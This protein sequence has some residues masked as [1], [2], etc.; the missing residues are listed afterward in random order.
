MLLFFICE[1]RITLHAFFEGSNR[2]IYMRSQN[3][4]VYPIQGMDMKCEYEKSGRAGEGKKWFQFV[5][6]N[7]F[8]MHGRLV[9]HVARAHPVL[10]RLFFANRESELCMVYISSKTCLRTTRRHG[11][12]LLHSLQAVKKC[13]RIQLKSHCQS[14]GGA[15]PVFFL[16]VL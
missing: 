12:I 9:A 7:V 11:C 14:H 6:T 16:H 3:V 5:N 15:T 13:E 10:R 1:H 2:Y 4:P 8:L